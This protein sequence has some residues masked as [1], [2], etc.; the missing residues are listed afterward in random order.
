MNPGREGELRWSSAPLS[1]VYGAMDGETM[2]DNA[3]RTRK[4]LKADKTVQKRKEK[5]RKVDLARLI[6]ETMIDIAQKK[7]RGKREKGS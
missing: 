1:A 4:K 2:H 7:E 6:E 3:C 5:K